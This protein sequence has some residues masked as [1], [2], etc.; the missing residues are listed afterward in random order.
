MSFEHIEKTGH[1]ILKEAEDMILTAEEHN[2][3]EHFRN[4]EPSEFYTYSIESNGKK[5]F[6]FGAHHLNDPKN[7]MFDQ[8][9]EALAEQKPD[10]VFVEG[11]PELELDKEKIRSDYEG[12]TEE[13]VILSD[14]E[15]GLSLKLAVENNIDFI[16]PEPTRAAEFKHSL[17]LGH[18]IKDLLS[19]YILRD[20]SKY[21]NLSLAE[22]L[23]RGSH[24]KPENIPDGH[25]ANELIDLYKE[26]VR[27]NY[28]LD[29]DNIKRLNSP[30]KTGSD[31]S[32]VSDVARDV[33]LHRNKT[34]LKRLQETLN[35]HDDVFIV[36]GGS[37]AI[38]LEKAI[39][40]LLKK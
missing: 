34:L 11:Y 38:V 36:Y 3:H 8:I 32:S 19:Y 27:E 7:L 23:E 20:I 12:K 40:R 10:M 24:V 1:E 33:S 5:V 35:N 2:S 28:P 18:S 14:G 29:F 13:E 15:R 37:H 9:R 22:L 6:F 30:M 21:Q 39:E 17:E 4:G 16:S 31:R 26:I 25:D